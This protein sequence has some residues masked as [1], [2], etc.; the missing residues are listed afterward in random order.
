MSR[1]AYS[2][3][4]YICPCGYSFVQTDSQGY[5]KMKMVRRLHAKK[6][7]IAKEIV[8]TIPPQ[9]DTQLSKHRNIDKDALKNK[10]EFMDAPICKKLEK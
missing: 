10:K 8:K 6:C 2:E 9:Y 4:K 7:E 1:T 3:S 5:G